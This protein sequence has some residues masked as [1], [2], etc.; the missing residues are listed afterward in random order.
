MDKPTLSLEHV[1]KHFRSAKESLPVLND[2][3]LKLHTG[4]QAAITGES[5][6]GKSTL[7]QICGLLDIQSGGSL[8]IL[9]ESCARHNERQR[10]RFRRE[11][12]GFVYQ[13]HHLL[14]EFS[15]LENILMPLRIAGKVTAHDQARAEELLSRIGLADRRHH[16]PGELSGG[17]CQRVAILRAI[18]HQPAL[19]LADEPTGNLDEENTRRVFELFMRLSREQGAAILLATHSRELADQMGAHYRLTQG[20]LEPQ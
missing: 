4:E 18:I 19:I 2:I 12:I 17:E 10:T 15:A 13:F 8:R 20:K 3:N 9:G 1:S 7:L 6:S 16:R 5:G 14:A 11:H